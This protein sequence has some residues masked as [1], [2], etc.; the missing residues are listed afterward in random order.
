MTAFV[1]GWI[2]HHCH[3]LVMRD[4]DRAEI[5]AM[6]NEGSGTGGLGTTAF[7]SM[8]GLAVRRHCGPLLDLDPLADVD[9]YVRR[10]R[11]LGHHEVARRLLTATGI[12]TF[13]VDTGYLPEPLSTPRELAAMVATADAHEVVRLELAAEQ[14]LAEPGGASDFE[15]RLRTRLRAAGAAGAVAA[16]SI[17]A[18]RTGLDL[19]PA[20]PTPD[21]VARVVGA[22]R[23]LPNGGFRIADPVLNG[24]LAWTAVELG[25]PLQL[26]V[27]Y[28]DADVN[29]LDCDPLRLTP[30]LRATEQL[31]V[32]I[33]LLHNYPFHRHASYLAQVFGHVFMDLGLAV[34]NTGALS[35]TVIAE[36]LELVPFG[37]LLFSTDA[38]GL[39]ELYLLGARLFQDG[40]ASVLAG[41][42]ER[43]E[44]T[45]ADVERVTTL[46]S[47]QNARRVYGLTL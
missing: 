33:M 11:E 29:L 34:H 30:F 13:V 46:V 26:H 24:Y 37:K 22:Q 35:R 23:P 7:D 3:G 10:R 43:H 25:I 28:G 12:T 5:E 1:G 20:K 38:F 17:A 31:G 44:L 39:P 4:L 40:L 8:L 41:L 47:H 19:P 16:K 45:A 36:T 27:G 21:E 2:D 15:A 14:L 42:V 18:Y 32:P 6:L 9:T